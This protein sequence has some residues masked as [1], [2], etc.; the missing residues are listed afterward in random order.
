MEVRTWAG[1]RLGRRATA[2]EMRAEVSDM[3]DARPANLNGAQFELLN[4][5]PRK[6][7][8]IPIIK[9]MK[10]L[11]LDP[12]LIESKTPGAHAPPR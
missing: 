12:Y 6:S 3:G 11:W 9:P 1:P 10:P 5:L 2:T 8:T 7:G 4:H